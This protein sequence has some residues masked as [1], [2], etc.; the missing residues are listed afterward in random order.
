M[1]RVVVLGGGF[2]GLEAMRVLER[3]LGSR[4]DI[5]LL[6]VSDHNYLLFTPL[7]PQVASSLVEPRHILQPIRDIRGARRFRFRRDCVVDVD[8]A[9]RRVILAE[10]VIDYDR[11]VIAVG[12]VTPTFGVPGVEEHALAYKHLE[13]A[14][15]LRDHLIDLAE[16]ADHE[17][18][19]AARRRLL[20]VCVVGGGYTGVELIAEVHDFFHSYVVPRYR[21]IEPDDYRLILL[22]AGDEILRGVH[23]TLAARARRRLDRQGIE[24]RTRARVSAVL[25]GGVEL[26][27]D[28]AIAAGLVVWVAGVKGHPALASAPVARDRLGRIVVNSQLRVPGYPEVYGAG[29]A[30]TVEGKPQAS[31]PIIPAALAHGRLVAENIVA[32][33]A[34][35]PLKAIEFAPRGMLVSLGEKDAVVEVM[36]FKFSGYAAWFF[37]NALHLYKLVGLR[38]QVQVALD[39]GLARLFPRDSAMMRRPSRCP[40]C[41]HRGGSKE[42]HAA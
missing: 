14:V 13:D 26:A 18:D 11:L 15:V 20:T 35:R 7:L 19:P 30:V 27:E 24:V 17:P 39:W 12:G 16:H 8:L 5:E 33:L 21:G 31:I 34:D 37:W 38:K 1:T 25:P 23:P 42:Y 41:A 2:A 28:G 36:G 4:A 6:L 29:D 10:G 3:R 9:A 40:V 32:D 22:E